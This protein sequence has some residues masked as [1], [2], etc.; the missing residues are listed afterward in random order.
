MQSESSTQAQSPPQQDLKL[1]DVEVTSENMALNVMVGFLN[2]AQR[3]GVFTMEESSKV[4][5]AVRMFVRTEPPMD[6]SDAPP[7]PESESENT[8]LNA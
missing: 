6:Q 4:W 5:E 3:R 2:V 8:V 7:A 1:T